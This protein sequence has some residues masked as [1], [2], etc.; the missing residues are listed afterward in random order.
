MT[1][2]WVPRIQIPT[3]LTPVG[4]REE[5]NGFNA[6]EQGEQQLSRQPAAGQGTG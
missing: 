6:P 3:L 5:V 4:Q 1:V 2:R